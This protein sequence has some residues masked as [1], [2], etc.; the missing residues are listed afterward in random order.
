MSGLSRALAGACLLL[1]LCQAALAFKEHEFKVG[2]AS[3]ARAGA[4]APRAD[5]G[6]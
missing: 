6:A 5:P 1:C 3:D 4:T 2:R